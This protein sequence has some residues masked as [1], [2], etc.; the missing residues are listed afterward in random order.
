MPDLSIYFA[1]AMD[2]ID[3]NDIKA[4]D[5]K[6][7]RLL[8]PINITI[9]NPYKEKERNPVE[10]GSSVARD[11][12]RLLMESDI[13]LADLSIPDYQYV[14][15]I[16]EIVHAANNNIPVVLVEGERDFHSRYFIQAYCD[17]IAKTPEEAVEY[18]RRTC[19]EDGIEGQMKEM[20][21]YYSEIADDYQTNY[22]GR[23]RHLKTEYQRER[24]SL[25]M[26]IR[27]RVT[28]K[29]FQVGIGTGD[30]TRTVCETAG[31]VIGIDQS[32]RMIDVAQDKLSNY[33]NIRFL[34]GDIFKMENGIIDGPF[35]CVVV[36]FLFSLLPSSMQRRLLDLIRLIL[37]PGG[38]LI[39]ADT[40]KMRDFSS[41]GL[42]RR[43]LQ[44]REK[45]GRVFTL[46]KEN[47]YG[48]SL[49]KLLEKERF[50]VIDSNPGATWFS[51]AVS[52]TPG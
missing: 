29:A 14:G 22:S 19:T 32:K 38:L 13:V 36:Y 50:E 21:A 30:W 49:V 51:W 46:Y 42:G 16:F 47:F 26:V 28:G 48:D 6:Y 27:N 24:E 17:F 18:I 37:K 33:G 20:H 39:I 12:L 35:D 10:D 3:V 15:C 2:A 5:E 31:N 4:A 52:R 45:G 43:R 41:V 11:D 25:R 8:R 44:R 23:N 34:Q 40:R 1:R 9:V 7:E